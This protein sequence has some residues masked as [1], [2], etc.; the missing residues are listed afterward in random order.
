MVNL[1][2]LT[3]RAKKVIEKRGGTDSLQEDADELK[4][5]AKGQGS[6]KDK[7]KAA[8]EALKDPGAKGEDR[9]S[10]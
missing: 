5:I 10:S 4:D 2:R 8:G 9:P 1:R 7:A 6:L 3:D